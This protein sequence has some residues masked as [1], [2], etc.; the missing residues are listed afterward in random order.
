MEHET[1]RYINTHGFEKLK[2]FLKSQSVSSWNF[3]PYR[4]R[5]KRIEY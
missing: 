4:A 5:V 2:L 3:A 1:A